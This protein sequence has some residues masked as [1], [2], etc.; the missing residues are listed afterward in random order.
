MQLVIHF[1]IVITIISFYII[2]FLHWVNFCLV[3]I[4]FRNVSPWS[5]L[6]QNCDSKYGLWKE[7]VMNCASCG[8]HMWSVTGVPRPNPG[9]FS[10]SSWERIRIMQQQLHV[11]RVYPRS[12]LKP[13][14]TTV[15]SIS[16]L[17]RILRKW[18][19]LISWSVTTSSACQPIG[20][21]GIVTVGCSWRC[22]TDQ[23]FHFSKNWW[24][25]TRKRTR[26]G[27]LN[28]LPPLSYFP[29]FRII[30]TLFAC[31]RSRKYLAGVATA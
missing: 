15:T 6:T 23:R 18:K 31:W 22:I 30:K 7:N 9:L 10:L 5:V 19:T 2:S 28:Q 21:I 29:L 24:H 11:L 25:R 27:V 17:Q 14:L 3:Y 4:G 1:E 12:L 13:W 20:A 8:M 26:V 16:F